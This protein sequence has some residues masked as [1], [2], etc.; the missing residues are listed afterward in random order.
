[1]IEVSRS[2]IAQ[3]EFNQ[4]KDNT[5]EQGNNKSNTLDFD[6]EKHSNKDDKVTM[7][8][9]SMQFRHFRVLELAL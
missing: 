8:A 1:M 3:Q 4:A 5:I 7:A 9:V 2:S 6:M